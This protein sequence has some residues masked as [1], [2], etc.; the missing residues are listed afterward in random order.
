MSLRACL[1]R[2]RNNLTIAL[3]LHHFV[4]PLW[5]DDMG[6]FTRAES[7][8]HF[9]NFACKAFR[10]ALPPALLIHNGWPHLCCCQGA[11]L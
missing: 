5:F 2:C 9:T 11:R 10:C 6:G 4:H 8:P 3:T 7:I 1:R